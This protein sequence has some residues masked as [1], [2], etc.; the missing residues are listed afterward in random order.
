M[1][2]HLSV[3][4]HFKKS[5]VFKTSDFEPEMFCHV[6][7]GNGIYANSFCGTKLLRRLGNG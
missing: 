2:Y 7:F 6:S 3:F 1:N 5:D 4:I